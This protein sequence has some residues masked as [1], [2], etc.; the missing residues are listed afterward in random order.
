VSADR[1]LAADVGGTKARLA[2]I[3][4]E[5]RGKIG[6]AVAEA[7]YMT[8]DFP[9]LEAMIDAFR[10][11]HRG[12][13]AAASIGFAGAVTN[14]CGVGTHVPWIADAAALARHLRV[15]RAHVINDLVASGYGVAALGPE[16]LSVIL[17][18]SGRDGAKAVK[19]SGNAAIVSAG[20]GLG[21][22]TLLHHDGDWIPVASEGGH[23]DFAARTD[24][25]IEVL[26]ALRAQF[27][28]V[29]MERV[30]SG[31]GLVNVARV[32]HARAGAGAA[33]KQHGEQA[34]GEEGLPAV[35]T[36]QALADACSSCVATLDLFVSVYGAEAGNA[37]LRGMAVAGVF[38]GG[39]IAPKILPALT[40]GRFRDAFLAKEPHR[41][42]LERIP[43]RVI[44][45]DRSALLGAAR[46]ATL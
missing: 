4:G 21:E 35:I 12:E 33:M 3:P 10:S 17:P 13:V 46:Y 26:R 37:A 28:R 11:V 9:S 5:G 18:G 25:E 16:E 15:G 8:H 43:V 34:G 36:G 24:L 1:I 42:L 23:A 44:L 40:D 38:L 29:S 41:E 14:G 39:G 2:L 31:I 27:G 6:P 30:L 32:L 20:T 45:T 22:T 19:A 7:T